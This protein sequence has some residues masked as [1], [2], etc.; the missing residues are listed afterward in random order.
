VRRCAGFNADQG[1]L[2][3]R[4]ERQDFS[5]SQAPLDRDIPNYIDPVNLENVLGDVQTNRR[6][7]FHVRPP[8][9]EVPRMPLLE[10]SVADQGNGLAPNERSRLFQ[11]FTQL[12]MSN[13]RGHGGIGLGLAISQKLLEL[14]G[15]VASPSMTAPVSAAASRSTCLC[16]SRRRDRSRI[17]AVLQ[18]KDTVLRTPDRR[19][20]ATEDLPAS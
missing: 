18:V 15:A 12:D 6:N 8:M 9:G 5:A 14:L 3:L 2:Q 20:P 11:P 16:R 10:F 7:L 17:P 1:G 4:E 19:T 13:S